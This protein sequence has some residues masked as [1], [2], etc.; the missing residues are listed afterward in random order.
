[1]KKLAIAT[2]IAALAANLFVQSH[3]QAVPIKFIVDGT[4]DIVSPGLAGTFAIGDAFHL[5]YTFESTTPDADPSSTYGR[6]NLAI[7]ALSVTVGTYS[8]SASSATITVANDHP[9]IGVADNYRIDVFDMAGPPVDGFELDPGHFP[10]M[11]MF[12]ATRTAF[13]SDTLPLVPPDPADFSNTGAN[14]QFTEVCPFPPCATAFVGASIVSMGVVS[15]IGCDGFM[16]PFDKALYLK[17]KTKRAI[18]VDMVLTDAEGFTVTDFDIAAPPIINVLFNSTVF[19]DADTD[20][21][22]LLP[23]GS[24]NEDNLFRF[25]SGQWIYNLGTKQFTAAGTYTV[26]VASGDGS[27]YAIAMNGSCTQTFVRL[28]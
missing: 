26:M 17:K 7:T 4:V 6:Y 23:L 9:G 22:E 1:M 8:A 18:P 5:E 3:A 24:A 11:I 25:D 16:P 27:E 2:A 21:A 14:L 28:P 12:D 15:I 13:A 19:G 10:V 20:D